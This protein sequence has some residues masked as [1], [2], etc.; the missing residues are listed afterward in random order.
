LQ[1]FVASLEKT[2]RGLGMI[3]QRWKNQGVNVKCYSFNKASL[4]TLVGK[5][6]G[7]DGI[8]KQGA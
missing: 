3:L 2:M 1:V 6:A 4:D 5:A 7:Y 8:K